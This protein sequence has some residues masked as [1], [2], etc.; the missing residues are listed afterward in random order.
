MLILIY[1]E[2]LNQEIQKLVSLLRKLNFFRYRCNHRYKPTSSTM[3][4]NGSY[5]NIKE[6]K[7]Y[8]LMDSSFFDIAQKEY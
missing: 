7:S 1:I 6:N 8:L 2:A 3:I 5:A 4:D